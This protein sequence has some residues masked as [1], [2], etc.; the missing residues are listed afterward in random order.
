MGLLPIL[1][2]LPSRSAGWA[3]VLT[4]AHSN[5]PRTGLPSGLPEKRWLLTTCLLSARD[6]A[7]MQ[8]MPCQSGCMIQLNT[9]SLVSG[10][11]NP[12]WKFLPVRRNPA[13]WS[14][15]PNHTNSMPGTKKFPSWIA[16][17]VPNPRQVCAT[18]RRSPSQPFPTSFC[19]TN[20]RSTSSSKT[21]VSN[22]KTLQD[23]YRKLAKILSAPGSTR[24]RKTES[25]RR[26]F[27]FFLESL[28][29]DHNPRK[30]KSPVI[31]CRTQQSQKNAGTAL[32]SYITLAHPQTPK[33]IVNYGKYCC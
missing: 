13:N 18:T 1:S 11:K 23:L 16:A 6:Q 5:A 12:A 20:T 9:T 3:L 21:L 17:L 26:I 25:V 8:Q 31:Y 2:H 24:K 30:C 29:Q 19:K 4:P 28:S 27:L 32:Q 22:T 7:K 14:N 33:R 15:L 10:P